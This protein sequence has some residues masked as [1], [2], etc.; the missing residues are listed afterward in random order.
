MTKHISLTCYSDALCVW[1]C[2]AQARVDEIAAKFQ[3]QV[4][5][6]HWFCSIFGDTASKIETGRHERGGYAGT[7]LSD[8]YYRTS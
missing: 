8:P 4:K 3:E 1:A 5:I 6:E 2:I 7:S